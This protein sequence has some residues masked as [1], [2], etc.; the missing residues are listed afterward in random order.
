MHIL[1]KVL[2]KIFSTYSIPYTHPTD[3]SKGQIARI[4]FEAC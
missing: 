2:D 4:D 1:H 3:H